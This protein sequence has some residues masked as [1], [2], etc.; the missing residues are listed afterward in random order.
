MFPRSEIKEHRVLK[1]FTWI[2]ITLSFV[3]GFYFN[4]R[5]IWPAPQIAGLLGL[6][7]EGTLSWLITSFLLFLPMNL[8]RYFLKKKY[9]D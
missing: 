1:I 6:E 4:I 9:P 7:K 8:V 3:I 2:A 5:F